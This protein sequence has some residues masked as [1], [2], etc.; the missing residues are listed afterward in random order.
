M[1]L[2]SEESELRKI[3]HMEPEKEQKDEEDEDNKPFEITDFIDIETWNKIKDFEINNPETI[4]RWREED[5]QK[6]KDWEHSKF[7][8]VLE[9]KSRRVEVKSER[10]ELIE[11]MLEYCIYVDKKNRFIHS[12]Y[13]FYTDRKYLSDKQLNILREIYM[14][15]GGN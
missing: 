11:K 13:N 3:F 10:Q 12:L 14:N 4:K 6:Q 7:L 15:N 9:N 8:R 2:V 1:V 5:E